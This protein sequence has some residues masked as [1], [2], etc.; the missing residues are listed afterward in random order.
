VTGFNDMSFLDLLPVRLTTIRIQ[1]FELGKAAAT[2]LLNLIN[3][4]V[5]KAPRET[6]LPVELMVRDSAGPPLHRTA[7]GPFPASHPRTE[8]ADS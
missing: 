3:K 5:E 2:I 1:Q 8:A 4:S 6:V 7:S